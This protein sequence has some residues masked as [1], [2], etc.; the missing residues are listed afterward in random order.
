MKF[1]PHFFARSLALNKCKILQTD[2]LLD[3]SLSSQTAVHQANQ[4]RGKC[5]YAKVL[6]NPPLRS[7]VPFRSL[8]LVGCFQHGVA[9]KLTS[10]QKSIEVLIDGS[11]A[12]VTRLLRCQ[13]SGA[14]EQAQ[15]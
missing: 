10:A 7:K 9:Q 5:S 12:H 1:F 13:E 6:Y 8:S 14:R 3:C 15:G 4:H 2:G 11:Q